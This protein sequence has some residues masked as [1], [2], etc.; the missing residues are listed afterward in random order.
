MLIAETMATQ[1]GHLNI[2]VESDSQVKSITGRAHSP[3]QVSNIVEDVR[4]FPTN[5]LNIRFSYCH[6]S[7]NTL[8]DTIRLERSLVHVSY[9]SLYIFNL[10]FNFFKNKLKIK[11]TYACTA[12]D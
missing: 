11:I 5:I 12:Q 8:A 1:V 2:I 4:K 6:R 3:K 10:P 9:Q 7:M